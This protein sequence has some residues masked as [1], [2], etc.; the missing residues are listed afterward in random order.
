[1]NYQEVVDFSKAPR[2]SYYAISRRLDLELWAEEVTLR[3]TDWLVVRRVFGNEFLYPIVQSVSADRFEAQYEE[4]K[5]LE[6]L[7]KPARRFT[8]G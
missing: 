4:E 5:S 8:L 7:I 3:P 2:F 6:P 1:L